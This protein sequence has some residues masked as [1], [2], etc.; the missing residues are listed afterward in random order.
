MI[1]S[2]AVLSDEE[3]GSDEGAIFMVEKYPEQ[4]EGVR[5]ALGEFGGASMN[6]RKQIFYPIQVTEKQLCWLKALIP[7]RGGHG[8]LIHR[9]G[10]MARLSR[11]LADLERQ[12]LPVHI[13][14][15]ASK[16]I[17][18]IANG[19]PDEEAVGIRELL[20]PLQTDRTLDR[21]GEL[22]VTFDPILHNTINVTMIRASEKINV[23]PSQVILGLDGCL[24]PGYTPEDL[25][26]EL[27]Q[28]AGE[29]ISYEIERYTPGPAEPDMGLF[30]MLS[31][32][33]KEADPNGIPV[34]MLFFATTD[35]SAFARLGITTYGFTPMK[36]PSDFDFFSTFH[37][38]DERI[39]VTAIDF[40][41]EA[42]YQVIKRYGL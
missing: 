32:A 7:G 11:Y 27:H 25:I 1:L 34:P 19:F 24:L 18:S 6:L 15:T 2:Y 16:M 37:N 38:A 41:A 4:F 5:F 36:L 28:L 39:P 26:A 29:D 22:A 12:R 21:N 10:T 30:D 8:S 14:P 17:T 33:L 35:A 23:V 20:D 3:S 31:E 40:G 13:T 9:G 42:L